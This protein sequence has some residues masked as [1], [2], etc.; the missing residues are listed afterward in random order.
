MDAV[1][2]GAEEILADGTLT[3]DGATKFV[4]L[5]RTQLYELMGSGRLPFTKQGRRRLIPRRALVR[6][7]A[8]GLQG[9]CEGR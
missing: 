4:G 1:R 9:G 3:V 7:L 6:L 8:N 5:G 2:N